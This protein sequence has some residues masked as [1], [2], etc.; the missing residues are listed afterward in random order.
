MPSSEDVRSFYDG[1]PVDGEPVSPPSAAS[2]PRLASGDGFLDRALMAVA[3]WLDRGTP[4]DAAWMRRRFG[5]DRLRVCDL[6]C[7]D[8]AMLQRI[9]P[10][11]H[12]LVGLEVDARAAR[13]ARRI[14]LEVLDG[15]IEEMPSALASRRFDVV[16]CIHVLEHCLDPDLALGRAASLL[17]PSGTLVVEVPN[18]AARGLALAGAAW[19]FLDVPRHLHFYTPRSLTRA[20]ERA[21]LTVTDVEYVGYHRQFSRAWL[22]QEQTIWDRL[23]EQARSADGLPRRSSERRARS[24]LLATLFAAPGRTHDSVRVLCRRAC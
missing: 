2:Y 22:E 24:L 21:G 12:A 1:E 3:R 10:L 5:P 19:P 7:G 13:A 17:S 16:F 4:I 11:G 6:G 14:G 20:V 15:A 8:G 23:R 9:A 18:N